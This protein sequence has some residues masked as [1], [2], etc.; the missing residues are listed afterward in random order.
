MTRISG[1]LFSFRDERN[2]DGKGHVTDPWGNTFNHVSSDTNW[3][4]RAK[5]VGLFLSQALSAILIRL[6]YRFFD[7]FTGGA[8]QRGIGE[9]KHEFRI[10]C[11]KKHTEGKKVHQLALALLYCKNVISALAKDIAQIVT[12]PL[13]II[14]LQFAAFLGFYFPLEGRMIYAKIEDLWALDTSDIP[15][16]PVCELMTLYSAPCMQSQQ[17]WQRRNLFRFEDTGYDMHSSRSLRL[18]LANNLE[19]YAPYFKEHYAALKAALKKLQQ[20]VRRIN[21]QVEPAQTSLQQLLE[22]STQLFKE[23]LAVKDK[24]LQEGAKG[25]DPSENVIVQLE[26]TL[27]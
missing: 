5:F 10:L 13:E 27:G 18:A 25:I 11:V 23:V 3:F 2:E 24:W 16:L 6:P 9:A 4:L 19:K 7:L 26:T 1:V 15:S 8:I 14:G 12:Y 22:K 21:S 20:T 17:T